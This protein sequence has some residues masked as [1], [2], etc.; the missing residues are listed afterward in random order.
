MVW[1][2]MAASIVL[3]E[4]PYFSRLASIGSKLPL[5]TQDD[6]LGAFDQ[7]VLA[8]AD[9]VLVK[10]QGIHRTLHLRIHDVPEVMLEPKCLKARAPRR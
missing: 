10:E 7:P 9:P 4:K 3:R 8:K 5:V 1:R 2:S 6:T